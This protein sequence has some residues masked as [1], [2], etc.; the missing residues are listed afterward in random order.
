[1]KTMLLNSLAKI[2]PDEAPGAELE[3]SELSA[4]RGESVSF[5]LAAYPQSKAERYVQISVE[6]KLAKDIDVYTVGLIQSELPCYE[7][8]D[9]FLLRSTRGKYPDVLYPYEGKAKLTDSAWNGIWFEIHIPET[10]KAGSYTVTVSL[11]V[12]NEAFASHTLKLTVID[13][14][15]PAQTLLHT[16][17]FHSDCLSTYYK[18]PV[19]SEEYWRIT[20]SFV[21]TAAEHGINMILTPIFTPP[22]DTEIGGERPTV[23]LVDVYKSG[24]EYTFGFENFER[25]IKMCLKNGVQAFE[26]SHLFTQWG[27]IAAP[28]IM[29]WEKD[30][31]K[32]LFGW[33]TRAGGIKYR[34]FLS[35]LAPALNAEIERLGIRE[36]C[37]FHVSDEPGLLQVPS[38]RKASR[39]VHE[40][41]PHYPVMDALSDYEFFKKGLLKNPIPAENHVEPFL[42]NTDEFWTYYC[43][44]QHREYVPNRFFSMPSQRNRVLGF[45]LYKYNA[46]GFLQ[47]GYNFWYSQYSRREIDP[48]K[49]SDADKAF[50]SGDAYVVYPG[51]DGTPLCSLRLK[52]FRD[53]FSDMRALQKLESLTSRE[54]ALEVLSRGTDCELTFK[55][56]PH[57]AQ[58]LIGKRAEINREIAAALKK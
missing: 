44:G 18:V 41:F 32:R 37:R 15:L 36:R 28:K 34:N 16:C 24:T 8:T 19:F 2:F 50:P 58:W 10:L 47:W 43:C 30:K 27:A 55:T 23:Q 53:G 29:G 21:K 51:K 9:D 7:D 11:S 35:Q 40:F 26:I 42:G 22:L 17:W 45:L 6:S 25:F 14:V 31:Y 1:M 49:V 20:E 38:Y 33:E 3:L 54:Y 57:E 52:V 56:Y 4:L 39:L 5:Q 46:A 12:E 13:A 48:F